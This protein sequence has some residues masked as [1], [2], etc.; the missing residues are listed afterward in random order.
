MPAILYSLPEIVKEIKT[1][2]Q[3]GGT[4]CGSWEFRGIIRDNSN[5]FFN[6]DWNRHG[7]D[8]CSISRSFDSDQ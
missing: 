5:I 7:I 6:A 3:S 8:C 4:S 1:I 2:E